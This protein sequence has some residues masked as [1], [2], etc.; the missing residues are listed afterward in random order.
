MVEFDEDH[1]VVSIE[2]KPVHPKSNYAVPELYYYDNRVID[3][4][5][6]VEPFA[7]GGESKS[8]Q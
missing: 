7:R 3:I 1:K 4:A 2:E 6:N 8:P 5:K